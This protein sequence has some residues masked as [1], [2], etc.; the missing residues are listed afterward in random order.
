MSY[1]TCKSSKIEGVAERIFKCVA[2]TFM[3]FKKVFIWYLSPALS[4]YLQV[5]THQR[6]FSQPTPALR[7]EVIAQI[8]D[9]TVSSQKL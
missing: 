6:Q 1:N 9:I 5:S 7:F 8:M 2:L 4:K 3:Y